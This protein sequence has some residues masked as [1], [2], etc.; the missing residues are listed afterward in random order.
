MPLFSRRSLQALLIR[1]SDALTPEQ[2]R[3]LAKQLNSNTAGECLSAQWE[4]VFLDVFRKIGEVTYEPSL[5]GSSRPDYLVKREHPLTPE[6][7]VEVTAV[8]DKH[9]RELNPLEEF[10]EEFW[11]LLRK[12]GLPVRGYNLQI[13][14]KLIEIDKTRR[15]ALAIPRRPEFP[16]FF[17]AKFRRFLASV[18]EQPTESHT[19]ERRDI[20]FDVVIGYSPALEHMSGGYGGFDSDIWPERTSTY[21]RLAKKERQIKKSGFEGPAG[22]VVCDAGAPVFRQTG[23]Y[24]Q[25]TIRKLV[26]E[27]LKVHPRV[28]FVISAAAIPRHSV[29]RATTNLEIGVYVNESAHY[30]CDAD[31][32]ERL[33]CMANSIPKLQTDAR[34]AKRILEIYQGRQWLSYVGAPASWQR[35]DGI[36]VVTIRLSARALLDLLGG[37]QSLEAFLVSNFLKPP[38]EDNSNARNPFSDAIRLGD[39][40]IDVRLLRS[41]ED[42]DDWI[43][44]EFR[45][46]D[47]AIAG[48]QVGTQNEEVK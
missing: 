42:D 41:T 29:F 48:I 23:M 38:G 37:Q 20:K 16:E 47:A 35:K 3:R 8:S 10:E 40:L 6:F 44:F 1:N 34:H 28:S 46:M 22:I 4:L 2:Q 21:K 45:G 7:I 26:E 12:A 14:S 11:R 24:H 33:Q 17:D 15:V 30:P 9:I 39:R 13:G 31:L 19:L 43:E 18:E 36:E 27:F 25:L 5:K 32:I